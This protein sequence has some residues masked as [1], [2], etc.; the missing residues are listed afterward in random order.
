LEVGEDDWR[1]GGQATH[2]CSVVVFGTCAS[3]W[4]RYFFE[5]IICEKLAV[6]GLE[7][8]VVV[9]VWSC[10]KFNIFL[11]PRVGVILA[12]GKKDEGLEG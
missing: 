4:V 3:T 10:Q 11:Y 9:G 8:G 2:R 7:V 5:E 6:D 1:E 12:K